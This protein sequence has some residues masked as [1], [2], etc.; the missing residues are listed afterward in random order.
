MP[1]SGSLES[2]GS[3]GVWMRSDFGAR[4][5]SIA[6]FVSNGPATCSTELRIRNTSAPAIRLRYG[7]RY[8]SKRR[9]K[10]E[11]Y[12][13]ARTSSSTSS[14]CNVTLAS[15]SHVNPV[16]AS[17]L[18]LAFFLLAFALCP[19]E[20]PIRIGPLRA[21]VTVEGQ[22]IEVV[23]YGVVSP[24]SSGVFRLDLTAD[25][26]SLQQNITEI[27][28]PQIDRSNRCGE[29]MSLQKATLDA[30]APAAIL[31][32]DVH[33]EKWGCAKAFG[34]EIAKKL[35]AGNGSVP[36]KLT[37]VVEENNVRLERRDRRD[38]S[39]WQP[40]RAAAIRIA[41][42]R[43]AREDQ[44]ESRRRDSEGDQARSFRPASA[45]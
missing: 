42:R 10:R 32:A 25:L 44:R 24:V 11:S 34:K 18:V 3:I 30:A 2:N 12:A 9:I 20:Q 7:Q 15:R 23:T 40:G 35:V 36:V 17:R 31:T 43:A 39:R 38:S 22:S 45:R 1:V 5:R 41:R 26:S 37:P 28:R 8:R 6:T 33:Y 16:M 21:A 14:Q 29:R 4:Y 27:L 13:F 19:Q